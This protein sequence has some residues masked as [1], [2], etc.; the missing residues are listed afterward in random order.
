MVV[1]N[2]VGIILL[3]GSSIGTSYVYEKR[4]LNIYIIQH[5]SSF[6]YISIMIYDVKSV[7]LQGAHFQKGFPVDFVSVENFFTA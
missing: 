4:F 3:K 2:P 6:T 1:M 5:I 7:K